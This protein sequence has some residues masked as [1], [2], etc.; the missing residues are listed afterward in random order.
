MPEG[1]M[2]HHAKYVCELADG[3]K[4]GFSPKVRGGLFR[5][6]FRHPTEPRKYV[7]AATGVVVPRGWSSKKS[8]PADWYSSASDAIRAAYTL[9]PTD[10]GTKA[11]ATWDEVLPLLLEG[12]DREASRRT[13]QSALTLLR[14]ECSTHTGPS[15]LTKGDA[16]AFAKRY[17]TGGYR[18]TKSTE[19]SL[20][21]RS[22]QTVSSTIRNLRA[23]WTRLKKLGLVGENIWVEVERPRV[24][25]K[26]PRIPTEA[27]IDRLFEWLDARFPGPDGKGWPLVKLF[28]DVKMLSGCRLNDLCQVRSDQFDPTAGTI[29]IKA[30]QDKTHRERLIHLPPELVSA[31]SA[32]K[33]PTHLWERYSADTAAYRPGRRRSAVFS[34]SLLYSAMSSIFR[35]YNT[36]NPTQRVKT[37]DLR[38]RAITL[39]VQMTGS[40]EAAALAIP[41]SADTARRHYMD[42]QRAFDTAELQK[43]MAGVLLRGRGEVP[44]KPR[45]NRQ[46]LGR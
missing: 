9:S 22:A 33:G 15:G 23:I 35:E 29:H 11:R 38:K 2:G 1:L 28:L 8:P 16:V 46:I 14:A 40:V 25:K 31:L 3:R 12:Y 24:P 39:T 43:R 34:P 10:S 13:C 19:G 26:L 37:H 20:R 5:V 27:A 45:A 41:I 4:V 32:L 44:G 42:G 6:Q 17:A 30:E 7:E 36:A 21:T 18:R